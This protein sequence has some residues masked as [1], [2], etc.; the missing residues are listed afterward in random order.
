MCDQL[1]IFCSRCNPEQLDI[2]KQSGILPLS[3]TSCGLITKTDAE[4]LCHAL[5]YSRVE[6]CEQRNTPPN[7]FKVYHE[8]F[9]K[10]KG[11]FNPDSYVHPD[12][13]CIQCLDCDGMFCPQKFVCHSHKNL[14]NTTCHWGFDSSNWRF[15]LLLARDQIHLDKCEEL[16]NQIKS[17]FDPKCKVFILFMPMNKYNI[18]FSKHILSCMLSHIMNFYNHNVNVR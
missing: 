10:C 17:K 9:G 8:C 11:L 18:F 7:C 12:A 5:L 2:L 1:H 3:I 14:E 4:R 15:Y 16:L 6:K 13:K